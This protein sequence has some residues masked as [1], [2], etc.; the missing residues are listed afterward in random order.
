MNYVYSFALCLYPSCP[1]TLFYITKISPVKIRYFTQLYSMLHLSQVTQF[2]HYLVWKTMPNSRQLKYIVY[3]CISK[4][5][6]QT[7]KVQKI[8]C[9]TRV[10]FDF[11]IRFKCVHSAAQ[12]KNWVLYNLS[13]KQ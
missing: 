2:Y 1:S 6:N 10:Y 3:L 13:I 11:S 5:L 4:A 9:K 7:I 8:Q 12:N